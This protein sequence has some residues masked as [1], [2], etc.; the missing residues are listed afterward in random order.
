MDDF[1]VGEEVAVQFPDECVSRKYGERPHV[2]LPRAL[3]S[4]LRRAG[5]TDMVLPAEST[6]S[7]PHRY[8]SARVLGIASGRNFT[9]AMLKQ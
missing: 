6:M 5:I 3:A 7:L 4:Q 9:F 1:E 2:D 8:F